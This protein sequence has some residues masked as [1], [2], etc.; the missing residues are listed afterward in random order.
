MVLVYGDSLSAAYGLPR[1][2]GWV[3]LLEQ[4]LARH[5]PAWQVVN[6]SV[7]GETTAGGR[8]RLPAVLDRHRP[9]IVILELGAN[10]GLRGLPLKPAAA[11]LAAMAA[12]AK[13]RGVR[14]VLVGMQ[15]PPNYGS[16]YTREFQTMYPALAKKSGLA[17][18]PFLFDG[19]ATRPELFQADGLHPIA[20]AQPRLLDNVWRQLEPMLVVSP[21]KR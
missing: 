5:Q 9:A 11:N 19:M 12:L 6:A 10:D 4:R 13:R 7:S 15:L 2:S 16:S 21:D 8:A 17:L 20:A 3:A 18:V 14:V 1:D